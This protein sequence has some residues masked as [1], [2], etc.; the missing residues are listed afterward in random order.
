MDVLHIKCSISYGVIYGT[1][2]MLHMI[3]NIGNVS[4]KSREYVLTLC[5]YCIHDDRLE[6]INVN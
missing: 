5:H 2:H 4:Q 6:S 3:C 1:Y